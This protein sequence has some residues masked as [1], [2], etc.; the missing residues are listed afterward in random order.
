MDFRK[1]QCIAFRRDGQVLHLILNRPECL[2]AVDALLDRKLGTVFGGIAADG[3]A[4]VAVT[5]GAGAP[6]APAL[7]SITCS[8]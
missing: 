8:G 3:E 2:N 4:T 7:T 6:S 1:Y 5:T